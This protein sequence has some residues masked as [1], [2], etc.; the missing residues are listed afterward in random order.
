[1]KEVSLTTEEFN[2]VYNFCNEIMVKQSKRGSRDDMNKDK[3]TKRFENNLI[4]KIGEFAVSK[5]IGGSIDLSVWKTGTR[6]IEQFEPDI[7]GHKLDYDVHV[8]TTHIKYSKDLTRASWTADKKDPIVDRSDK[9]QI[10][11]FAFAGLDNK[12]IV[13]GYAFSNEL[14]SYWKECVSSHMKHKVALYYKDIAPI[15]KKLI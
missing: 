6:G 5:V 11:V 4:G 9:K 7:V 1:M 15:V 10:I 3:G 13:L 12:A 8:K 14:Q 2:S